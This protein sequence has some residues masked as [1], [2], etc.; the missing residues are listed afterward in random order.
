MIDAR[1]GEILRWIQGASARTKVLFSPD[2]RL[3]FSDDTGALCLQD[4][5]TGDSLGRLAGGNG[6]G[7]PL[8][9]SP[10]GRWLAVC[11]AGGELRILDAETLEVTQRFARSGTYCSF[12]SDEA[13]LV[14]PD[15]GSVCIRSFPDGEEL[16]RVPMP[17]HWWARFTPGGDRIVV[18]KST[19]KIHLIDVESYA[20]VAQLSGHDSYVFSAAFTRDAERIITGSGDGTIRIHETVPIADRLRARREWRQVARRVEPWVEGWLA[21]EGTATEALARAQTD[22]RLSSPLERRVAAQ[23]ILRE[24]LSRITNPGP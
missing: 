21:A 9:F 6:G 19:G 12:S 11:S 2:G 22:P 5:V 3:A 1:T 10:S 7:R 17:G 15:G 23:L 13:L 20:E 8:T 16:A 14:C 24:S 18:G 4:P